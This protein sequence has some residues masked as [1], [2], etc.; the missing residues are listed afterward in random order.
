MQNKTIILMCG[1]PGSG[2]TTTAKKLE[3]DRVAIRLCP[4]DWIMAI[5]EDQN[6]IRERDRLRDPVEQLL[7]RHAQ[8]LAQAGN[9][10]IM[11]NGFWSQSERESYREHI[12]AMGVKAELHVLVAPFEVL[13]ERVEKRNAETTEFT[14][15][16]KE[17]EYAYKSFE[18][19][20][21]DEMAKYDFATVYN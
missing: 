20:T 4:D 10:V 12:Q 2:K 16:K 8:K 7:W 9:S 15:T 5:L 3:V 6:N 21:S 13:W 14:M 19:P 17:L 11:E 18:V 1:L